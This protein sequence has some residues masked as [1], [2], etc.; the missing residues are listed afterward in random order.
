M[1]VVV[2][3]FRFFV[4][5][6]ALMGTREIW[7]HGEVDGLLYFTNQ[8]GFLL[9]VVMTWAGIA[10]LLHKRQPPGWFK[11]GVTLFLVIT[12]LVATFVLDPEAAGTPTLTLGLTA[13][14]IEHQLNPVLA[15]LDFLLLDPH[16]RM[17]WR[18][19]WWWLTY[20]VAYVVFTTLRGTVW[21]LDYPYGFIDLG[22]LGW[23]GLLLNVLV[24]GVG[25]AG[26]GLVVILLDRRLPKHAILGSPVPTTT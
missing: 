15:F 6:L 16:R 21:D 26:L 8:S 1:D 7:L 23:G 25:F 17:R 24:Y 10:S 13:G 22:E 9:A 19:A 3:L 2:A 11:G 14:Q 4:V 12:G 18:Y 5:Y 20:L